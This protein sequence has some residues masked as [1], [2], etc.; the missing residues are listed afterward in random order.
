VIFEASEAPITLAGAEGTG[1]A[2]V[3][4][5]AVP[6]SVT[7]CTWAPTHVFIY[8]VTRPSPMEFRLFL[9]R[10][11]ALFRV[12]FRWTIRLLFPRSLWQARLVYQH[13]AR[14]HLGAR[15]EPANVEVLE[16]LFPERKRLTE[17]EAGLADERYLSTSKNFSAPSL[18]AL[19]RQ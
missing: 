5:S 15:L 4:G 3:L 9:L 8:L 19:Y 2:F 11:V 18:R 16:W 1:A 7:S 6:A 13:A 12:L 17:D 14:E 10:H